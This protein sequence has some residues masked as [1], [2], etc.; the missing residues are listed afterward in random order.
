MCLK[1]L[2]LRTPP[3][4]RTRFLKYSPRAL[5]VG[6]LNCCRLVGH[7]ATNLFFSL[8]PVLQV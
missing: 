6:D 1:N 2:S 4:C 5:S 7:L 8:Q 3:R